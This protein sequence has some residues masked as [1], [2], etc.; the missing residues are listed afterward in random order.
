[1]ETKIIETPKEK[2]KVEI[3]EWITGKERR[4]L[5]DVFLSKMKMKGEGKA[6]MD[7]SII[8]SD[9]IKEMEDKAIEIMIV[10]ING[11]KD[12]ILDKILDMKEEDYSFVVGEVKKVYEETSFL[13]KE[14]IS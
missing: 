9:L 11:K 1:M 10:S 3:K 7:E 5:R 12:K 6:E 13:G 4:A 8:S 2:H 14:P